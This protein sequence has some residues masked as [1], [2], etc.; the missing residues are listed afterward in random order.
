MRQELPAPEVL[1]PEMVEQLEDERGGEAVED[2]LY[3]LVGEVFDL[4]PGIR[5]RFVDAV[6]A[7]LCEEV[8][9][10]EDSRHAHATTTLI[11]EIQKGWEQ[12][13]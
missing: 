11:Q 10:R 1:A 8:A 3:A 6:L 4:V 12:N 5:E 7:E 13:S 9:E 2:Y